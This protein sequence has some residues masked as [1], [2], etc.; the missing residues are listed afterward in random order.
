MK[1]KSDVTQTIVR[2]AQ[3][4]RLLL[5]AAVLTAGCGGGNTPTTYALNISPASVT[6]APNQR[7]AFQSGS[8]A[9]ADSRSS[10]EPD[11]VSWEVVEG[12]AGGTIEAEG[13]TEFSKK[14][15]ATYTAP[16]NPGTYH[17]KAIGKFQD[18]VTKTSTA[19]V[20]VK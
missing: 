8:V 9:P 6:L 7:Q 12:E 11:T 20:E 4:F 19:T 2:S 3:A 16:Q 1:R 10:L 13:I 17:V 5:A 14:L 15:F 18:G